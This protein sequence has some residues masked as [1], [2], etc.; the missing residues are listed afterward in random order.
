MKSILHMNR[1]SLR[2]NCSREVNVTKLS[3]QLFLGNTI[4]PYPNSEEIGCVHTSSDRLCWF[5]NKNSKKKWFITRKKDPRLISNL[6]SIFGLSI[7]F[8]FN[9]SQTF[10]NIVSVG[11]YRI[12]QRNVYAY[13]LE[14]LHVVTL[15]FYLWVSS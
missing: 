13:V 3:P 8:F 11:I 14:F 15:N 4:L 5:P 9:L 10:M 2:E 7:H 12:S 6:P 1:G